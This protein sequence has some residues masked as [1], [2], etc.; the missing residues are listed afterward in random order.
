MRDKF[1]IRTF[2]VLIVAP[3][4]G[5]YAGILA[6]GFAM[7]YRMSI[8]VRQPVIIAASAAAMIVLAIGMVKIWREE[9]ADKPQR[10]L[11]APVVRIEQVSPDRK[12]LQYEDCPATEGQLREIATRTYYGASISNAL[13]N[14]FDGRPAYTAWR[15]WMISRGYCRWR[16]S[17]PQAGV[18][19]T[20]AGD[21]WLSRFY[22][23][24]ALLAYA[25]RKDDGV[26][27]AHAHTQE[28]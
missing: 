6:L 21:E 19:T 5:I 24:P 18:E 1:L 2:V 11:P 12:Q 16:G 26:G 10:V 7:P 17:T 27:V 23:P 8:D 4:A 9:E 15:D 28:E 3:T 14:V 22:Q 25:Y 20:S 13:E